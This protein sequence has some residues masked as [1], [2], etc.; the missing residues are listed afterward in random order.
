MLWSLCLCF[1][2]T[3]H[4]CIQAVI[5][6]L[7]PGLC[8]VNVSVVWR[9]RAGNFS[10][11]P[12]SSYWCT[13]QHLTRRL[14]VSHLFPC[15]FLTVHSVWDKCCDTQCCDWAVRQLLLK[16]WSHLLWL[17]RRNSWGQVH[18]ERSKVKCV[19]PFGTIKVTEVIKTNWYHCSVLLFIVVCLLPVFGL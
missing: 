15:A 9:V 17:P 10:T 3:H 5:I 19:S 12:L 1:D 13:R 18:N 16:S 8:T 11:G 2:R 6:T 14:L 7:S 4:V